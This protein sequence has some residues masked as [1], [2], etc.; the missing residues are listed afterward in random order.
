MVGI[1]GGVPSQKQDIRLGDVVVGTPGH[2]H[3]GVV[4]YNLSTVLDDA[5]LKTVGHLNAP[6][7]ALLRAMSGQR[8][9]HDIQGDR[10]GDSI[11]EALD[12]FPKLQKDNER[13]ESSLDRLYRSDFKHTGDKT[14]P[15][16]QSCDTNP[17]QMIARPDREGPYIHYGIIASD[18]VLCK[19][20]NVRDKLAANGVLCIEMEAA[21][22]VNYFPCL[23]IRGIADYADTHKNDQWHGYAAL[24]AAAYAK[25]L[26]RHVP[27]KMRK[28]K[29]ANIH[30]GS[31]Y[32]QQ[33]GVAISGA[34][35]D[36][37]RYL[38]AGVVLL[39]GGLALFGS[40]CTIMFCK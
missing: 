11:N 37:H 24:A 6:P 26:L 23:V 5:E 36:R 19:N 17:S 3:G 4:Q 28:E 12:K 25:D 40:Y 15:C 9:E 35:L 30:I 18:N 13:P 34:M 31:L 10:L 7:Q 32:K 29:T 38:Q 20:A 21:G 27:S 2:G 22:L 16:T 39:V 14:T 33:S 8:A 1:G